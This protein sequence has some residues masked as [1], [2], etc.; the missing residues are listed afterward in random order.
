MFYGRTKHRREAHPLSVCAMRILRV[1]KA[2]TFVSTVHPSGISCTN[3]SFLCSSITHWV[4]GLTL[5][6]PFET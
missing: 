4:Q 5:F 3:S 2:G 1:R 6:H